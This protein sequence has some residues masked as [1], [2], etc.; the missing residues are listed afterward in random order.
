MKMSTA[1]LDALKRIGASSLAMLLVK[2]G[3]RNCW[4][5]NVVPLTSGQPRV[6]GEAYTIRYI[7]A[8]TPIL[9]P[10]TWRSK[11]RAVV[12][13]VPE[14]AVVVVDAMGNTDAGVFGDIVTSGIVSRRGVALITDGVLIDQE[15]VL[16][17]G[18]PIW[19][20]PSKCATV[21]SMAEF[22]ASIGSQE[23]IACGRAAVYPADIIVADIDG[24]IV[25]PPELVSEFIDV[26]LRTE[27][28]EAWVRSEIRRGQPLQ[29]LHPLD[30]TNRARYDAY[31]SKL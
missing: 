13:D 14:G 17:T 15:G 8:R 16:A 31:L 5:R 12:D 7:P 26:G 1:D 28:E 9:A 23:P 24:V 21:G 2:K 27:E 22:T 10:E 30:D 19:C 4:M 29:G 25:I 3:Y 6:A 18:L 11:T 20:H